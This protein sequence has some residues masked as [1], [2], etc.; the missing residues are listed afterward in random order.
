MKNTLLGCFLLYQFSSFAQIPSTGTKDMY[1]NG[2]QLI[3]IKWQHNNSA[4][5]GYI[6]QK[7]ENELNWKES[8]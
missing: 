6:I 4:V 7:S 3:T 5:V 2:T 8:L 1:E